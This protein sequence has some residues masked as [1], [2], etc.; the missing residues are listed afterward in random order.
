[1][2]NYVLINIPKRSLK[3]LGRKIVLDQ[4]Q[5]F[6]NLSKYQI[7]DKYLYLTSIK[8]ILKREYNLNDAELCDTNKELIYQ[9]IKN[10]LPKENKKKTF[11]INVERKGEHKFTSTELARELA[12]SVFDIYPDIR[13][14]LDKP[15]LI[16]HIKVLSNKC[17]I[18]TEQG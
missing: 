6:D 8:R 4:M 5:N 17:L 18:Y 9:K 16:V 14:D 13:V 3:K 1:M 2:N 11:A 12:G 10:I 7:I 15:N